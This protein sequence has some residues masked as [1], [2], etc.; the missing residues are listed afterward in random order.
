MVQR[1]FTLGFLGILMLVMHQKMHAQSK[2][3]TQKDSTA[4]KV[5]LLTAGELEMITEE[6]LETRYLRSNDSLRV[7]FKQD[8]MRLFCNE[9]IQFPDSN[10]VVAFGDVLFL[11]GDSIRMTGDTLFYYGNDRLAEVWGNIVFSDSQMVLTTD[12]LDFDMNTNL[13]SYQYG[14]K[15]TDDST[16]LTSK[17]G[18]YNTQTKLVAFSKDVVLDNPVSE[19]HLESDT[20]TYNT[21]TKI[22]YFH[23]TTEITTR[24]G[25]LI[26]EEGQYDSQQ[27][28]SIFKKNAR[29]ENE[30]YTL[31]GDFIDYDEVLEK[32]IAT[33]NVRLF[34][35]EDTVV[36]YGDKALYFGLEGRTEIL[37]NAM[38]EKPFGEGDTLFVQADTL[39]SINDSISDTRMIYAYPK[40]K[41]VANKMQGICDSMV[42][43]LNDSLINF[44]EDPVLWAEENQME[45]DTIF[46]KLRA[47]QIDKM[48]LTKK[49]FITSV[50]S[51]KNF[52]QIKGRNMEATFKKSTIRKV[53]VNGNA[54]SIYFALDNDTLLVGMNRMDCS[55]MIM[56]FADSNKLQTITSIKQIDAKFIPPHE[57]KSQDTQL[58]GFNWRAEERPSKALVTEYFTVMPRWQLPTSTSNEVE[59]PEPVAL[60][61][62]TLHGPLVSDGRFQI[63]LNEATLTMYH[64]TFREFDAKGTFYVDFFPKDPADLPKDL[65]KKG[66]QTIEFELLAAKD[67]SIAVTKEIAL[68]AYPL[69]IIRIGQYIMAKGTEKRNELWADAINL[70]EP[71]KIKS[72]RYDSRSRRIINLDKD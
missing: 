57:L 56:Q 25:K 24:D 47:N 61:D 64:P 54:Q 36:I 4:S 3:E 39:I 51:L 48:Y 34:S 46:A 15:I 7:A 65:R 69:M 17:K 1:F 14:G 67:S 8:D 58:K 33:G 10:F 71:R 19:Y 55:N 45:A 59:G 29:I 63:Y 5:E 60:L 2:G 23:A 20:L 52:N 11:K 18:Y 13:A 70:F 32:G 66:F 12:Q 53:D 42:Y 62:E 44:Y 72:N 9:A 27:S 31:S 22:A 40:V 38:V 6:G 35:K 49:S 16:T 41:L 30:S 43:D 21:T 37:G 26:A 28:K 68:P 50:D